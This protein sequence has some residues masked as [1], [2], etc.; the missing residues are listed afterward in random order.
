MNRAAKEF[1][2]EKHHSHQDGRHDDGLPV[3]ACAN[4]GDDAVD[5]RPS[6]IDGCS[7]EQSLK[8]KKTCMIVEVTVQR[9][10]NSS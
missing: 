8:E 2:K 3:A 6:E 5:E 1:G 9:Q 4:R 7:G 10:L